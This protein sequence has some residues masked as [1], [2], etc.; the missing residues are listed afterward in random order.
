MTVSVGLASSRQPGSSGAQP[1]AET[2]LHWADIAMYHA[3]KNGRDRYAWFEPQMESEIRFRN[4][5]ESGLRRGID[6]GEFVPYYQQQI[7]IQTGNLATGSAVLAASGTL[8]PAGNNSLNANLLGTS[9][10]VDFRWP[11]ENGEVR[12]MISRVDIALTGAAQSVKID[13]KAA[14]DSASTPTTRPPTTRGPPESPL[15]AAVAPVSEPVPGVP[16]HTIFPA[17]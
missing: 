12:A 7:D 1:D 14:L 4:A 3:K 16:A 8:D 9:G 6:L 11:M 15:H 17:V 13:A 2:L 5:L 10:P